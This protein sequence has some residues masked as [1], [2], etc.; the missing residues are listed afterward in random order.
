MTATS[1]RNRSNA[2]TI[3]RLRGWWR[4]P[5]LRW[6]LAAVGLTMAAVTWMMRLWRADLGV[7]FYYSSDVLG[8]AAHFETILETGWYEYQPRLGAPYGQHYH[9]YPFSDDLHMAMAKFV[10]AV[11]QR[12]GSSRSTPITC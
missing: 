2:V 7:P 1:P 6:Y 12:T 4:T 11:H 9:D 8:S 10:G 5:E 3:D